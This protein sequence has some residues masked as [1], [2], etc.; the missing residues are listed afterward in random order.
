MM[1][2]KISIECLAIRTA[3]MVLYEISLCTIFNNVTYFMNSWT[4]LSV[5]VQLDFQVF[6]P[7]LLIQ[8]V[9]TSMYKVIDNI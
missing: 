1:F 4:Q 6:S 2:Y 7:G 5:H 3:A 9:S 8:N